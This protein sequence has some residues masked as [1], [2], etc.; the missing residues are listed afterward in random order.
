MVDFSQLNANQLEAVH[1]DE[2][3]LLVLAGPGSGKTRVLTC[4]IARIIEATAGEYFRVLGLTYTHAAAAEM[5]KRIDLLVPN[6]RERILLTA[7]HSFCAVIL[8]QHGH[9]IGLRPDFVILTQPEERQELLEEA[10][11]AVRECNPDMEY[12][13]ERLLSI[14][15]HLLDR[16]VK[17]DE[18]LAFLIQRYGVR[19]PGVV[20]SVYASYRRLMLERNVLDFGGLISE[21]LRLFQL[22][23]AVARLTRSIYP[24]VCV[25][26]FQDVN[27]AQYRLLKILVGAPTKSLFAVADDAQLF[28]QRNGAGSERINDLQRDFD[29][30]VIRLPENYRCPQG[31]INIAN[32]LI[33]NNQR[34][35]RG[36]MPLRAQARNRSNAPIAA[37]SFSTLDDETD[38]VAR[39]IAQRSQDARS[40]CVILARTRR[41]LQ[42]A[43][44][45]LKAHKVPGYLAMRKNEFGSWQMAWLHAMLRLANAR[46][47]RRQ[48]ERICQSFS[49]LTGMLLD[50]GTI[51]S[52]G[53][54]QEG[55]YLRAWHRAVQ[56]GNS[57]LPPAT[58]A[59]LDE[60]VPKLSERLAFWDF[61]EDGLAWLDTVSEDE[62]GSA[63][64]ALEFPGEKATWCALVDEIAHERG[65]DQVTLNMLLQGLDLRSKEPQPPTEAVPCL[66]IHAAKGR[67]FGH[68]Y[69]IGLVEDQLPSWSAIQQGDNSPEM[70]EERRNCFAAITRAQESL[71]LTYA[72]ELFGW[73]TKPSR[74]LNE[75]ELIN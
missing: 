28:Y 71:A 69:L 57:L 36:K 13:S 72:Y 70:Q 38:W 24:L 14:V 49:V 12:N 67:E 21:A 40:R 43:L 6:A 17:E 1:W 61:I 42:E 55:D 52:D 60:S 56:R 35:A 18:A 50:I 23:P 59:F 32:N 54:A 11:A 29:M 19:A 8:R 58:A 63:E 53:M 41:V 22:R 37:Q 30:T 65:L 64:R 7:F 74:F 15:T 62:C 51:V 47:D 44:R 26:D 4:R 75:M 5:L 27:I 33:A 3:H 48:L 10:M 39:D 25:D 66:T 34:R 31:I 2:G 73:S 45:S 68:V 20:S 16:N 46:H 9:H